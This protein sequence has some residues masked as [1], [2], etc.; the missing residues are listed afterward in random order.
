M[1]EQEVG[2]TVT[3]MK[4]MHTKFLSANLKGRDDVEYLGIVGRII[5]N[6]ILV[7]QDIKLWTRLD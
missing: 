5:S 4:E 7:E 3:C 2:R 1:K 6:L